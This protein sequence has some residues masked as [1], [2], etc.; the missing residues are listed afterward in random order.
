MNPLKLTSRAGQLDDLSCRKDPQWSLNVWP[1][2]TAGRA[3]YR[4]GVR[5]LIQLFLAATLWTACQAFSSND[6]VAQAGTADVQESLEDTDA[7]PGLSEPEFLSDPEL[8]TGI[9]LRSAEERNWGLRVI[10]PFSIG[11]TEFDLDAGI[12]LDSVSTVSLVPTLEFIFPI[13]NRWT[14]LPFAGVGGA[15]T[16]GDRNSVGGDSVLGLVTGG[17]RAQMWQPFADRYVSLL[18]TEVRYD[19]AL[20]SR[21]GLLGDWGSL[22]GAVEFRRGF[23]APR[24]G[25]RFQPGVYAQGF[26]F[27]DPIELE[28]P[29]VTPSFVHNQREFGIS[30][31]SS[32]PYRIWG[33][34]LPRVFVGVRLGQGVQSLRIRFSR[35]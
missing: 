14:L 28:I 12:N 22:T 18:T 32:T 33:I 11:L 4:M 20:T 16:V 2:S 5:R 31:G 1:R 10:F 8:K 26:W 17:L 13:D 6:T 21:N 15:A 30:L 35:L 3:D 19:A 24:D 25:P 23:G 9:M 7:T 27:W 34:K 29:G